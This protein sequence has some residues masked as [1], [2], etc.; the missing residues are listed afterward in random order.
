MVLRMSPTALRTFALGL[1]LALL[2]GACSSSSDGDSLTLYSGRSE[3]LVEPL[4][5][6]FTEETGIEVEVK[7]AG[8]EE[9][10]LLIE[11]E[12]DA[13]PADVFLSQS[14]GAVGFLDEVGLL[15][16]LPT[17]I[18]DLV[19]VT[20]RD[21][22]NRWIG[23]SGRQR[24]LVYNPELVD[25]AELPASIFEL[26]DPAWNG[27]LGIAPGNGSF[28]DFVTAMRAT[29]GDDATG[30]WLA[31]LADNDVQQYD[32]NSAIVAAVGRGEVAAGLVNH[33]YNYR[34][35]AEDPTHPGL[36]HQFGVDDPGSILIVTGIAQLASSE[37]DE[38]AQSFISWLLGESAQQFF[39]DET[40]EYPL[41]V[42]SQPASVIPPADFSAVGGIDFDELGGGLAGTRELIVGAGL[43][44]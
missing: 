17:E 13:S 11:Q 31:G 35:V 15:A 23:V 6:Q 43:D 16:D 22:D 36:N 27:R 2:T 37:N 26:T 9:L 34:F 30:E 33:Y 12:G 41:A 8:S 42:G 21:D 32:G 39:T 40:F 29:T 7:F 3:D 5:A 38:A 19:P 20:V 44:G 10:A 25:P 18:L 4:L 1:V 14:P 28:Q 24:V